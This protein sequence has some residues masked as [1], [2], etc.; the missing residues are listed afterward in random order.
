MHDGAY[1]Q[2][3]YISCDLPAVALIHFAIHRWMENSQASHIISAFFEPY[4]IFSCS[5][6]H[7]NFILFLISFFFS[8]RMSSSDPRFLIEFGIHISVLCVTYWDRIP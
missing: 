1:S 8:W 6:R 4:K 3:A 5:T 2:Q 7:N